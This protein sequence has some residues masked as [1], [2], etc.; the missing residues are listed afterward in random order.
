MHAIVPDCAEELRE[1]SDAANKHGG[2]SAQVKTAYEKLACCQR[3]RGAQLAAI[4]ARCGPSQAAFAA[5]VGVQGEGGSGA[6]L[7]RLHDFL[8]CAERAGPQEA[9]P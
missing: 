6:C 3:R 2:G 9:R 8:A 4:E 5:C 1:V 7:E